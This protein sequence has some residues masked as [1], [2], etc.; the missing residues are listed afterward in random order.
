M[1]VVISL[2]CAIV[3]LILEMVNIY[4]EAETSNSFLANYLVACYN[5]R[6]GWVP[7]QTDFYNNSTEPIE[8]DNKNKAFKIICNKKIGYSIVFEFTELSLITLIDL[9]SILPKMEDKN[10]RKTIKLG[11]CIKNISIYKVIELCNISYQRVNIEFTD[12]QM[13]TSM[14]ERDKQ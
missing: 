14:V 3:H 4:V 8:F 12:T 9:I 5:A 7:Q 10:R 1:A 13:L 2:I 11:Y 6:Q